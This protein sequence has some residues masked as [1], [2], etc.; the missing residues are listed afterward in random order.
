MKRFLHRLA[1]FLRVAAA[2][3]DV[4]RDIR[5]AFRTLLRSPGF[6]TVTV[7]LMSLGIG[8]T[9]TLFSLT[10]GVVLKPLPWSEPDRIVRLEE[11][12]GG[13]PGR[14]PWTISNTTYHAW[15]EQP[16]TIEEI[17]GWMRGQLMTMTVGGG[18]A[19]RLR[20]GRVTPSLFRVLR[21]QP[22][23]GRLFSDDDAAAGK[24][25]GVVVLGFGLWQRRFGGDPQVI[26]RSFR[27]DDRLLTITGVMERDFAFPDRETQAW[28][29]LEIARVGAGTDV[30]S[31]Q[32]FNAVARLRPG[33]T[34]QQAASE[35]TSRG[36]AAPS[37]GSAGV[38]LFGSSADIAVTAMPARDALTADVRP[39]LIMLLA[40]VGLLFSTA[41]AS[42]LVLQASRAA[43]RRREMAVRMAIGAGAGQLARQWVVESA[44]VGIAAGISGLLVAAALHQL[45]PVVLPPD[46]P[47]V[48]EV[49]LDAQVA[50]FAS[51]LTLL[52]IIVCG[53]VPALQIRDR[54][55]VESLTGDGTA[56]GPG[57]A[58]TRA[59]RV[60]TAMMVAQVAIACVL[61]VGTGLLARSFAA[62]LAADRGF[63]PRDLLTAHITMEARP[64]VSLSAGLE[65]AQ[66]RLQA[67]PEVAEVGF[68]NALPFVTTGGL[69]GLTLPSP[70]DPGSKVQ[71]QAL[72][73]T[74]SPEYF[75]AMGLRLIAGR[76]L[77]QADSAA[78]RPVV[79]VNRTFAAQ[80]LDI[81]P[82]GTILPIALGARREWEVVGVVDDVR[83]GGLSGVAPAAF[84][85]VEDPP[86]PE[87]FFTYRQ[88]TGSVSELVYVIRGG[89]NPAALASTLR[90]ILREEDP[91]LVI[92]SVMTMEDRVMHSLARP[93]TYAVLLGGFALFALTIAAVG[94]FGVMSYMAAQRTREIGIRTA[95][96]AQP[97]DILR[98]VTREALAIL[99]GGLVIG[100]T[101][102]FLLAR[103]LAPLIYG[104]SIH[105]VT[106]F[107]AVP[108]ILS[109]IVA[110]ACAVPARR[111]TRVSPLVAMRYQ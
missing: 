57:A 38:A 81:D 23:A 98:L 2:L 77:D 1:A 71:V 35:A 26:G 76:A 72:M 63:D 62:L 51:I 111:A 101:A 87:M 67:L 82:I 78:S 84:G 39:A 107:V 24:G 60:R 36:R 49:A 54:H 100:L 34:A 73:R 47:R 53:L 70:K 41:I 56:P 44:I 12:R 15:R 104:V 48:D 65:R 55:L 13:R 5:H 74:V 95:L 109:A 52:A 90:A 86:Q 66:Q 45:L 59:T 10:Y 83:Q 19:E 79:V 96:G 7:L 20:V 99:I 94:L 22:R 4:R 3:D 40:A 102:A 27:L 80:Y 18:E 37:L 31:G 8:A 50:V 110:V 17:G 25:P 64:F 108:L 88:W 33:G 42:V 14:V 91:S 69:G 106:S 6:G 85:G 28:L 68:G 21:A 11:T 93:R 105:D 75:P 46:F 97:H 32:I 29:P 92:D 89:A 30:I 9:T 58:N 43:K 103:S 16:D 61:L